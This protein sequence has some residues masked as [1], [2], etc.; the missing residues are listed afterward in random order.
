MGEPLALRLDPTETEPEADDEADAAAL[1]DDDAVEDEAEVDDD[2][3]VLGEGKVIRERDPS[4]YTPLR[5]ITTLSAYR[6][7]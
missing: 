2:I 6:I 4:C 5:S 3:D 1:D 7:R